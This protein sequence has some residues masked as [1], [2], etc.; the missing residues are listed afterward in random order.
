VHDTRG[1]AGKI[2]TVLTDVLV[3]RMHEVNTPL[4]SEPCKHP[5][6][7]GLELHRQ[8]LADRD[9]APTLLNSPGHGQAARSS[10]PKFCGSSPRTSPSNSYLDSH[11]TG[12]TF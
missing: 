10:A 5:E 11:K 7:G 8:W 2:A 9:Q 1:R 12:L 6:T 3:R 4:T